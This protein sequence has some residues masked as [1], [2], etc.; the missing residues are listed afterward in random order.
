MFLPDCDGLW[1]YIF[2]EIRWPSA[3]DYEYNSQ[4]YEFYYKN[5]EIFS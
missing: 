2:S 4:L 5:Y 3:M 1:I